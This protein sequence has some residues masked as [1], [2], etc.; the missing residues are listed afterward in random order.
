MATEG[1]SGTMVNISRANLK[2]T[3]RKDLESLYLR[4]GQYSKENGSMIYMLRK[5]EE[6]I[7]F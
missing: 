2:T 7:Y 6:K 4:M 3:K 5:N 1:I